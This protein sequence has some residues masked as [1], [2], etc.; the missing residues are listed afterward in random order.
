MVK[1]EKELV[2]NPMRASSENANF[3]DGTY[4]ITLRCSLILLFELLLIP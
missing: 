2:S 3:E 1:E 4:S